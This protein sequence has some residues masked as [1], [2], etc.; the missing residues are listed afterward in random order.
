MNDPKH[1]AT[2]APSKFLPFSDPMITA[3]GERRARVALSKLETL[4]FNTGTL[5]NIECINCYIESSPKNDQLVYLT[6]DEVSVYLDEIENENLGTSEIGFTGGEPFMNPEM[7]NILAHTL[8]RGFDALVLTN[9]MQPMLRPAVRAQVTKLVEQHGSKLTFR[10]SL[11]HHTAALH[12]KERGPGAFAK[13]MEG[14]QFLSTLGATLN[15]AGRTCWDEPEASARA[16]YAALFVTN[17]IAV[18]PNDPAVL[19]LFPE[20]D[21]KVDV[22]EITVDCWSILDVDPAT[23]MCATSRMVVKHKGADSPTVVA[24]TLLPY[25]DGFDFGPTL[26]HASRPVA[27]NHRHCAKFCVL[28]GGSCSANS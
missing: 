18:D 13:A 21:E 2:D 8:G 15:I 12:D 28:G 10:V 4:W 6:L 1:T 23:M 16:G 25:D 7:S 22:P 11:D 3:K 17:G 24:C 5:C 26:K 14:L 27:L 9:A 19:T 20:M